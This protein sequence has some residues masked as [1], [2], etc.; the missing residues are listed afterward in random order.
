MERDD[1]IG[2]ECVSLRGQ[3]CTARRPLVCAQE[4]KFAQGITVFFTEFS[5]F[6]A[7]DW[8]AN[9]LADTDWGVGK[10]IFYKIQ[11]CVSFGVARSH[12]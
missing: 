11:P 10:K 6:N 1:L 2:Q 8:K 12:V 4:A 3:A 5:F 9:Q 7:Y